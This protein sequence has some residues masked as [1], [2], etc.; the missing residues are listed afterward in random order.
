MATAKSTESAAVEEVAAVDEKPAAKTKKP[1]VVKTTNAGWW[2]PVC[3]RSHP[4]DETVCDGC[5]YI[6]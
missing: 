2:C 1:A 4:H 3:D 5:G 6:R